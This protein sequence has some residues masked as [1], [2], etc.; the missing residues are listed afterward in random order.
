MLNGV[1]DMGIFN[2]LVVG[3]VVG[4][5][6]CRDR[7]RIIWVGRI[8]GVKSVDGNKKGRAEKLRSWRK[9]GNTKQVTRTKENTS[10][11]VLNST[12]FVA[13]AGLV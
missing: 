2:R 8:W 4:H 11:T 9:W 5:F 12:N 13:V 6:V 10:R 3:V 1:L 7:V